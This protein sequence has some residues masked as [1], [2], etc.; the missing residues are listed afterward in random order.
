MIC[1]PGHWHVVVSLK[2]PSSPLARV[3]RDEACYH[4]IFEFYAKGNIILTDHEY[5]IV[6][7]LRTHK[8]VAEGAREGVL[9]VQGIPAI[10]E[11]FA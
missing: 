10:L 6:A 9:G 1:P 11:V 7:L 5:S 4:L 8:Q 3:C 2:P